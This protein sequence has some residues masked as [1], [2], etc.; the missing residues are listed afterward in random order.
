MQP[1]D[2][3]AI[4]R[5]A[6]DQTLHLA[7]FFLSGLQAKAL[8][9]SSRTS[10]AAEASHSFSKA[11]FLSARASLSSLCHGA[12]VIA[13]RYVATTTRSM[14]H[15]VEPWHFGVAFAFCFKYCIGMPDMPR[16]SSIPR[17][18]RQDAEPRIEFAD[19][20]RIIISRRVQQQL[21]PDLL[22]GFTM[23]KALF[24]SAVNLIRTLHSYA[25]V[26][27]ADG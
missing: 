19:W 22:F 15:Q 18:R 26:K 12:D 21:R 27:R 24:R 11:R 9:V 1:Q 3:C 23:G 16:W 6:R 25:R 8:H 10:S 2:P 7:A 4:C 17:H 13:Q 20:V 5:M 14:E